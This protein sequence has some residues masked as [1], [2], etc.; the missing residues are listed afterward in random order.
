MSQSVRKLIQKSNNFSINSIRNASSIGRTNSIISFKQS[1]L[2]SVA[3]NARKMM[4]TLV[5]V[6]Q[7]KLMPKDHKTMPNDM[8]V[9]SSIE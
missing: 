8:L 3:T 4:S 1:K 9:V 2:L 6:E 7:A 5:S